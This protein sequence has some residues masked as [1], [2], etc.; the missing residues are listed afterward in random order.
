EFRVPMAEGEPLARGRSLHVLLRLWPG[1]DTARLFAAFE[2]SLARAVRVVPHAEERAPP[3]GRPLARHFSDPLVLHLPD[4]GRVSMRLRLFA[5][6]ARDTSFALLVPGLQLAEA[7]AI[8]VTAAYDAANPGWVGNSA[9]WMWEDG[10]LG[11]TLAEGGDGTAELRWLESAELLTR[12]FMEGAA[13]GWGVRQPRLMLDYFPLGD[14]IDHTLW[15]LVSPGVPAHDTVVAGRAQAVR[16]RLWELVD[17][18]LA[19]LMALVRGSPGTRLFVTGDHGMRATWRLFR[20]NVAL[21]DAG[22]LVADSTGG[23]VLSRTVAASPNGYWVS[24]NRVGRRGGI[25]PADAVA[26][27][28]RAAERALL[29]VRDEWGRP[30][31]TRVFD[32]SAPEAAALGIGGPSGGDLY[33]EVADG[34]AW[35]ADVSGAVVSDAPLPVGTH[36]FPSSAADMQTVF[37]QWMPGALPGRVGA[38]RLTD[39]APAVRRWLGIP[40]R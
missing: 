18:R 3:R 17:M 24:V 40:T 28:R 20:P 22:L 5:L 29:G 19:G 33:Y 13:W 30:V 26:A 15:G 31:V 36:G 7:N 14:D 10:L 35:A 21:R 38:G 2:R 25:V 39:V 9:A 12:G 16:E 8:A 32:A 27:V 37:C 34:Y 1:A 23:I 4:G 6:S 11:P